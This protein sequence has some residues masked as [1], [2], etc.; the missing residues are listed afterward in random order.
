[1][2]KERIGKD[3]K[4][5]QPNTGGFIDFNS[6]KDYDPDPQGFRQ[7]NPRFRYHCDSQNPTWLPPNLVGA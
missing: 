3:G 6:G 1:M 5:R 4:R 2:L 7:L